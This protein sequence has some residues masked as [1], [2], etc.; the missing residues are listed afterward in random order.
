[1][2]SIDQEAILGLDLFMTVPSEQMP[3]RRGRG[4]PPPSSLPLRTSASFLGLLLLV[5]VTARA[6]AATG[7]MLGRGLPSATSALLARRCGFIG[8]GGG[9]VAAAAAAGCVSC[10][11]RYDTRKRTRLS[12]HPV[13]DSTR[14]AGDDGPGL[15][16]SVRLQQLHRMLVAAEGPR[17]QQQQRQPKPRDGAPALGRSPRAS[18]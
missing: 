2:E 13:T 8:L 11:L 17:Q 1:M 18:S 12:A 14:V 5:A 6:T 4:R 9:C 10:L 16:A 3:R 15:A 7:R